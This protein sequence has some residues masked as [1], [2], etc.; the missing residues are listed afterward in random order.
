MECWPRRRRGP[1]G[2]GRLGPG[3]DRR[4][5]IFHAHLQIRRL[6]ILEA[7][8]RLVNRPHRSLDLAEIDKHA[9]RRRQ[10]NQALDKRFM[11]RLGVRIKTFPDF[12]AG[13]KLLIVK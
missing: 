10:L 4:A 12:V 3:L 13:K 9:K 8:Q 11:L 5:E 6:I 7:N 2:L 1:R